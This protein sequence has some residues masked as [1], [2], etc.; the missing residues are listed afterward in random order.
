M[1]RVGSNIQSMKK[2]FQKK[3]KD[4][5]YQTISDLTIIHFL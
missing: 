4:G 2:V 3:R 1:V 5:T